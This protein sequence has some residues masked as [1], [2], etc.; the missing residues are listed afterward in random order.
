[1]EIKGRTKNGIVI[2]DLSGRID[3]NA[4][5]FIEV[6]GECLHDGYRDILCNFENVDFIDYMGISVV[7]IAYKDV[8]NNNGR[9]K[10]INIPAHLRNLFSITGLDK[11]MDIYV[12]EELAINSFKEDR[13]IENIQKLQLRRRFK[14][15][16]IDIKIEVKGKYDKEK[17]CFKTDLLDLSALGAYI[18]GCS[19]FKLGDEV[20]LIIK[21]SPSSE[22]I[23]LDARVVWLSDKQV[24]QHIHPGMGVEFY[25]IPAPVQKKLLEFIDRNFSLI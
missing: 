11:A 17:V 24:Q 16:P 13:V 22:E 20:V 2:L 12:E 9:M 25:N 15:L 3:V 1:M 23:K 18:Y 10:F 7:V 21:L 8:T 4:A 19:Q 14:R 6:I 5:N